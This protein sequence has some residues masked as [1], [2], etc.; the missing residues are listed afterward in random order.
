M[1]KSI[2]LLVLLITCSFAQAQITPPQDVA[3]PVWKPTFS[4]ELNAGYSAHQGV[5][6]DLN[7]GV[8]LK[9]NTSLYFGVGTN[10]LHT[11]YLRLGAM[12]QVISHDRFTLSVGAGLRF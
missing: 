5:V 6:A 7:L 9:R 1:K 12:K 8:E 11:Q 3:L 2:I 4:L 10:G